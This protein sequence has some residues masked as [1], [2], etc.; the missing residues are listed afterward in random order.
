MNREII[1]RIE[2]ADREAHA[3]GLKGDAHS[4]FIMDKL[5]EH[6]GELANKLAINDPEKFGA[7]V[8]GAE[9]KDAMKNMVN[10][11]MRKQIEQNER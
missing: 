2:G 1:K 8:P 7:S 6:V 9:I 11:L 10:K 3:K 5:N 4:Q